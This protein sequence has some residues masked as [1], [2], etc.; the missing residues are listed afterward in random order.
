M[1]GLPEVP[2]TEISEMLVAYAL[3]SLEPDERDFVARNLPRFP[4]WQ[5]ELDGYRLATIGLAYSVEPKNVPLRAR[6]AILAEIDA[7]ESNVPLQRYRKAAW[8]ATI[9][10]AVLEQQPPEQRNWKRAV[11]RVALITAM[12]ATIVAIVFAMYT[13][14]I[15][16]QFTEQQN[17]LA[18]FQQVRDESAEVLTGPS[19]NRQVIDLIP[20]SDAPFARGSLFVDQSENAAMLVARS[21]PALSENEQFV[22]WVQTSPDSREFARIGMLTPNDAGTAQIIVDPP[23]LF[24]RYTDVLVTRETDSDVSSPSGATILSAGI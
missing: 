3:G 2:T 10:A 17:E 19:N 5:K 23:D 24:S 13:V 18:E 11:P 7:I 21:L 20:S 6:A 22:V 9:P 12:P 8:N 14:I 15:H 4:E 1:N 16:N